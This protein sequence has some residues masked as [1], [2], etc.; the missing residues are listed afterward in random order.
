VE[1]TPGTAVL[2][3][4]PEMRSDERAAAAMGCVSDR[5][6]VS[7]FSPCAHAGC[8]CPVCVL[9]FSAVVS[10]SRAAVFVGCVSMLFVGPV[11]CVVVS[12]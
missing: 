4:P 6:S 1:R 9:C 8:A 2:V 12:E 7:V 5:V 11:L 3:A 10:L